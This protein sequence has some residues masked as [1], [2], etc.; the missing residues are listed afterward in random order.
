MPLY[1]WYLAVFLISQVE[2]QVR[3]DRWK[4]DLRDACHTSKRRMRCTLPHYQI[5]R[6]TTCINIQNLSLLNCYQVAS[7]YKHYHQKLHQP[8]V[9]NLQ[10]PLKIF[11]QK[12][13]SP[14]NKS[15]ASYKIIINWVFFFAEINQTYR[16]T[17]WHI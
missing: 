14:T 16:Q 9:I 8:V 13:L 7:S 1:F 17:N 4:G 2:V 5:P 6:W 15:T 10:L 11:S 12:Y 3:S